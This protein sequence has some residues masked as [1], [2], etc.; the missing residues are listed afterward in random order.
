MRRVP[1]I[2][3]MSDLHLELYEAP[4]LKGGDNRF[5]SRWECA[6]VKWFFAP[7]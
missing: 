5:D 7:P 3:L 1:K 6:S 2:S 4:S